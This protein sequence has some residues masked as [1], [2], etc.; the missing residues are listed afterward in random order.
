[1]AGSKVTRGRD[2]EQIH[3][4]LGMPE[5]K[6]LIADLESTRWTGRPGYPIRSM[7][8]MALVKS[9]YVLPTWTRTARLVAEHPALREVIG[10]ALSADACYRFTRKLREHDGAL[11]ACIAAVLS[12]LHAE[13]PEMARTSPSTARTFPPTPTASATC[14]RAGGSGSGSPTR[15]PPGV[16]VRRSRPARAEGSAA[17]RSTPPSAPTPAFRSRGKSRP[18]APPK[19][20]SSRRC[21][22]R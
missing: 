3:T 1:M 12:A 14:P 7:V 21:S 11:A 17:T 2:A 18:R 20:R 9:R 6:G 15:T 19:C 5:I 22:T 8:G 10:C 13:R 4:L 16:T